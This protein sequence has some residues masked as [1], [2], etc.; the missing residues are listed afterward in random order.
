[1]Q[2]RETETVD[3]GWRWSL[4]RW[5]R[6]EDKDW[7]TQAEAVRRRKGQKLRAEITAEQNC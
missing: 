4:T 2:A 5:L 6:W 1:M 3:D 7:A